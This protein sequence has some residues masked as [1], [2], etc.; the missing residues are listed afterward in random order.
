MEIPPEFYEYVVSEENYPHG[1]ILI[2][3][4]DNGDWMY[5]ILDGKAKVKKK[6]PKGSVTI[7]VL[8]E[9]AIFGEMVLLQQGDATRFTTVV[10]DGPVVIGGLD[11]QR[12]IKDWNS[13]TPLLK[14]LI[15]SLIRR[16]QEASIKLISMVLD[17]KPLALK[18]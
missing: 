18:K 17:S 6:T 9:G 13:Q 1:T 5:V 4:D 7:D 8:R 3:E 2:R 10:A 14:K 16:R 11:T 15:G 12:L